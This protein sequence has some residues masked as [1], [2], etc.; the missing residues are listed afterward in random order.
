MKKSTVLTTL[1]LGM[2]TLSS[3]AT[4]AIWD[5]ITTKSRENT[6]TMR[7][8]VTISDATTEQSI[9]ASAD[10]LDPASVTA[11]G[12]VKFN[13]ANADSV[14]KSLALQ[15]EIKANE[16][17]VESTDYTI[18]FTGN[19]VEGKTDSSVTN[20]EETY[21][22]TITFTESGLQKLASNSNQCTVAITATL[23]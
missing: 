3:M 19:G 9:S 10:T 4:Y 17:L 6:V 7:N 11:S 5:T 2:I 13:V 21:N 8:P 20:G 14:A 12:H 16:A 1:T 15:E 23:Q 18:N 22:Y